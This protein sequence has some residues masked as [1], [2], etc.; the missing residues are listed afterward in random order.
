MDQLCPQLIELAAGAL[1]HHEGVGPAGGDHVDEL[2]DGVDGEGAAVGAERELL[3]GAG[4]DLGEAV[5][6]LGVD[7]GVAV[8]EAVPLRNT[9][10]AEGSTGRGC[11]V[12]SQRGSW[13]A[14]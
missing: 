1:A 7:G 9:M 8:E 12:I 2:V 10:G 5:E 13:L 3:G 4:Q 14:R 11:I 6:G